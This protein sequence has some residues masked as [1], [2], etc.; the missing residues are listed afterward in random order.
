MKTSKKPADPTIA[1]PT[2]L[3]R[4]GRE[5]ATLILRHMKANGFEST[6]GCRLFYSPKEWEERGEP[7]GQGGLLVVVYDGGDAR[8]FFE[9]YETRWAYSEPLR[10]ALAKIGVY[11]EAGTHWHSTVYEG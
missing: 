1:I 8:P 5:A 2:G 11:T 7:Y 3:S 9:G 10:E 4:K 6:G